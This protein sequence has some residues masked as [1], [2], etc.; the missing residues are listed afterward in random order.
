MW[1]YRLEVS[2]LHTV[3]GSKHRAKDHIHVHVVD[4]SNH[5]VHE[6]MNQGLLGSPLFLQTDINK[7]PYKPAVII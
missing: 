6:D 1:I 4:P 5:G 2:I 7:D 3:L